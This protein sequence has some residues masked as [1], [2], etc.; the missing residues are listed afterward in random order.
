MPAA[1]E[2]LEEM[3]EVEEMVQRVAFRSFQIDDG[4]GQSAPTQVV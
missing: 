2:T 4:S 3:G 1:F